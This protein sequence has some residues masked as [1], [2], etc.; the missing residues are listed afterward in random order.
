MTPIEIDAA[1]RI[2]EV[3]RSIRKLNQDIHASRIS[4][5]N[6]P[7][8]LDARGFERELSG[9]RRQALQSAITVPVKAKLDIPDNV[10]I[11]VKFDSASQN[12]TKNI[13]DAISAGFKQATSGN[14]FTGLFKGVTGIGTAL[15]GGIAS[16]L[17]SL[18]SGAVIGLT[19]PLGQKL[20]KGLAEGVE[21]ELRDVI[22]SF[23]L[24]G[25]SI[26]LGLTDE[27]L[28]SLGSDLKS[29]RSV[30]ESFIP[31]LQ[32]TTESAAGRN[33]AQERDRNRIKS[34]ERQFAAEQQR[35]KQQERLF[36]AKEQALN[37][38]N[39][40][41]TALSA[42]ITQK[43]ADF[44]TSAGLPALVASFQAGIN[45]LNERSALLQQKLAVPESLRS[46]RDERAIELLNKQIKD[47]SRDIKNAQTG[48]QAIDRS[49]SEQFGAELD[50]LSSLVAR[51]NKALNK[52]ETE[53]GRIDEVIASV[54]IRKD[55]NRGKLVD[56][57]LSSA[58]A[59]S[60]SA[61]QQSSSEIP[62]NIQPFNELV[63]LYENIEQA[64]TEL[65]NKNT[66][67]RRLADKKEEF[68]LEVDLIRQQEARIKLLDSLIK[69]QDVVETASP[70][71]FRELAKIIFELSNI[72]PGAGKTKLPELVLPGGN[73]LEQL[74]T[75]DT[76]AA[77]SEQLNSLVVDPNLFL[78]FTEQLELTNREVVEGVGLSIRELRK[79]ITSNLNGKNLKELSTADLP[80]TLLQ[81]TPEESELI[82]EQVA[83][84]FSSAGNAG[85]DPKVAAS[86]EQDALLFE[87]RYTEAIAK[88]IGLLTTDFNIDNFNE[89]ITAQ[90]TRD[91]NQSLQAIFQTLA[92]AS[93][94]SFD[95]I[96]DSIS[97]VVLPETERL[98]SL[99]ASHATARFDALS[100]QILLRPATF[101]ELAKG[102]INLNNLETE[103]IAHEIRHAF[104]TA[105]G[106]LTPEELNAGQFGV[107]LLK[108][109]KEEMKLIG[110]DIE[111]SVASALKNGS[112]YSEETIRAL[113]E[114]AY[115]FQL[116]AGKLVRSA[117]EQTV[118]KNSI[119]KNL[120]NLQ[121]SVS[122]PSDLEDS[123]KQQ[124][125]DA[126]NA[127]QIIFEE[128]IKA[129]DLGDELELL[130]A[131]IPDLKAI[132]LQRLAENPDLKGAYDRLFNQIQ[133]KDEDIKALEANIVD[134]DLVSF[135]AH[136]LRHSL[137]QMFGSISDAEFKGGE[138]GVELLK[139]TA[140][141]F[142]Q[143][144]DA[145]VTS[146]SN[147]DPDRQDIAQILE[148]DAYT[149]Q[150][151]FAESIYKA[152]RSRLESVNQQIQ[153]NESANPK[154]ES[155]KEAVENVE[156]NITNAQKIYEQIFR[157]VAE[158]SNFTLYDFDRPPELE[159]KSLPNGIKGQYKADSNKVSLS[160]KSFE[161]LNFNLI[162]KEVVDILVHEI[163]H[164]FQSELGKLDVADKLAGQFGVDLIEPTIEELAQISEQVNKSV[165]QTLLSLKNAGVSDKAIADIAPLLKQTET[166]AYTFSLRLHE[167]IF[168]SLLSSLR[169]EL[170]DIGDLTALSQEEI[171]NLFNSEQF[172]SSGL[173]ELVKRI[174]V[175]ASV[176]Q[177]ATKEELA[178]VLANQTERGRGDEIRTVANSLGDRLKNQKYQSFATPKLP[179]IDEQAYIKRL[180][181]ASANINEI[182][183]LLQSNPPQTL[184]QLNQH[185]KNLAKQIIARKDE[186]NQI[187]SI[188]DLSSETAQIIAGYKSRFQE[189]ALN[190]INAI[191]LS[192]NQTVEVGLSQLA[193]LERELVRA[194][195]DTQAR[196]EDAL[197]APK[198]QNG[199]LAVRPQVRTLGSGLPTP[200]S[201]VAHPRPLLATKPDKLLSRP[202]RE[203]IF[204][205]EQ[206]DAE[207][208]KENVTKSTLKEAIADYKNAII[209][210]RQELE[211]K[212]LDDTAVAADFE[213]G[214]ELAQTGQALATALKEQGGFSKE[215]RS[216]SRVSQTLLRKTD[217]ID[218][219]SS[220]VGE[221]VINGILEGI[222]SKLAV[223]FLQ[224]ETLGLELL[225]GF[226]QALDIKSPSGEFERAM[227]EVAAGG[228]KG[229]SNNSDRFSQIGQ[230]FAGD[231]TDNFT[232]QLILPAAPQVP[233]LPPAT[234]VAA[235]DFWDDDRSRDAEKY[236]EGLA[237]KN[238]TVL[239][240]F[241]KTK[242]QIDDLDAALTRL[243]ETTQT[244]AFP[245]PLLPP[246]TDVAAYDFWDDDRSRDAEKYVE[247]LADKNET[248]LDSFA[249]TKEQ[250]D[251]LD[252]AL[253]RL[254][255]TTQTAAFPTPL[256]PPAT[257]VAA[258]DFWDDDR[259]RDAEKYVEGLAA[260]DN[261]SLIDSIGRVDVAINSL[262]AALTR[263]DE[264]SV[265]D[266]DFIADP[267]V[268]GITKD[269]DANINDRRTLDQLI[270][271]IPVEDEIESI[272][273]GLEL[274]DPWIDL[275]DAIYDVDNSIA[276]LN[277]SVA[278]TPELTVDDDPWIDLNDAI[279]DV[280]NSIKRTTEISPEPS[281]IDEIP[282]AYVTPENITSSLTPDPWEDAQEQ[283]SQVGIKLEDLAGQ[284][285]EFPDP[286]SDI[287]PDPWEDAQ[288]QISQVGIKLED[289]AGQVEEFP[290]PWSDITPDPWEDAQEQISQV[291]I[292]LEDLAGQV[293]EFP[294]PWSDITPDPWED[295]QEQISQVGIKL[296]D[297]AGQVEEFP[298]P[299]S[300]IT[301]DPWE[302]A[303]EQISQVGIKLEDLAGQVEE[304][305]DPW[306]DSS[307]ELLGVHDING[308]LPLRPSGVAER[309]LEI[310]QDSI[311][312]PDLE[313][314]ETH[315]SGFFDRLKQRITDVRSAWNNLFTNNT[316]TDSQF[317]EAVATAEIVTA[318]IEANLAVVDQAVENSE[319][320]LEESN[321]AVSESV[322]NLGNETETISSKIKRLVKIGL[323]EFN[324]LEGATKRVTGA[325]KF[326]AAG[327]IA[328]KAV[329][330]LQDK[331]SQ[332][333]ETLEETIMRF[334][335][336]KK[337]LL[338]VNDRDVEKT[339]SQLKFLRSEA[340]RLKVSFL[341]AAEGFK[342]V[343][344]AARDTELEG[345]SKQ[346]YTSVSQAAR[347]L[348]LDGETVKGT[349]KALNDIIGK[350]VVQAEEI[351]GQ[352]GDRIPGAMQIAARAMGTTTQELSKL[353]ETGQVTSE[354]F[355]PKFIAQLEAETRSG[356]ADS[357]KS[358]SASIV[359]LENKIVDL[360]LAVGEALGFAENKTKAISV[361]VLALDAL[362][363]TIKVAAE[364]IPALVL[365]AKGLIGL[366]LIKFLQMA[367][368]QF[369]ALGNSLKTLALNFNAGAAS[370]MKLKRALV[371]LRRIARTLKTLFKG[372]IVVEALTVA[373]DTF[374]RLK[375]GIAEAKDGLDEIKQSYLDFQKAIVE[376]NPENE[377]LI[378][379]I[380][381][382]NIEAIKENR[383]W[384]MKLADASK[385][386]LSSEE[387][388]FL[389]AERQ[390][391]QASKRR[392]S[393][394]GLTYDEAQINQA[395]NRLTESIAEADANLSN[396]NIDIGVN[397]SEVET[398]NIREAIALVNRTI[399]GL[400]T[401][402]AT[403]VAEQEDL[404][405]AIA[406][407]KER[408]EALR[409]ELEKRFNL[410]KSLAKIILNRNRVSDAATEAEAEAIANID[411]E[412][413]LS[414]DLHRD[415]E[416]LKLQLSQQRIE[417][418][419]DN[420]LRTYEQFS[421]EITRRNQKQFNNEKVDLDKQKEQKL[422]TEKSYQ[423]AL[424]SL[425]EKY[426]DLDPDTGL[427]KNLTDEEI[428]QYQELRDGVR[429]IRTEMMENSLAIAQAEIDERLRIY[430]EH[431]EKLE[432]KRLAAENKA[433]EAEKERL[434]EIQQLVNDDLIDTPL[435]EQLKTN[436]TR[437]RISSELKQEK[438]KLR[439]LKRFKS[440][441]VEVQEKR[442]EDIKASRTKVLDLTLQLLEQ[443]KQAE[444]KTIE[445]I[446][447]LRDA[448]YS[449]LESN[450]NRLQS[451][452]QT[453]AQLI[454]DRASADE[455]LADLEL[456][457]LRQAVELRKQINSG[458]LNVSERRI[459]LRQLHSLGVKGRTNELSLLEKI[460]DREE[461]LAKDKLKNLEIQQAY[462]RQQLEIENQQLIIATNRAKIEADRNLI[463]AEKEVNSASS[464]IALAEDKVI[465]AKTDEELKAA[466]V[467][468]DNANKL[469]NLAQESLD[470]ANK[471]VDLSRHQLGLLDSTIAKKEENLRLTQA[472]ALAEAKG[473]S[474]DEKF[475]RERAEL[476]A[477]E[478]RDRRSFS[479]G[480]KI[481]LSKY[482]SDR[483]E[484]DRLVSDRKKKLGDKFSEEDEAKYRTQLQQGAIKLNARSDRNIY[485]ELRG[486]NGFTIE[487][488]P[489]VLDAIRSGKGFKVPVVP[490][491]K[492]PLELD[493]LGK[494]SGS[495]SQDNMILKTLQNIEQKFKQP[496][497]VNNDNQFINQYQRNDLDEI[498]RQTRS[499][500]VDIV[501]LAAK[502]L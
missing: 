295:A 114:D 102:G 420:E 193:E 354:E 73:L 422:I 183:S 297:L 443:E 204:S 11:A 63:E 365:A 485:R 171:I 368:F 355:I 447:L 453:E 53:V 468:L 454:S 87:L 147:A 481:D 175:S 160:P 177:S 439:Q 240:S 407:Q 430:D 402:T 367:A 90:I 129:S 322:N 187:T 198:A 294:D 287:T 366:G 397:L 112:A 488:P 56:F 81:P 497:V 266:T 293:E 173:K 336:L 493:V 403:T 349:F 120:N 411:K 247:G 34:A 254:D 436:L 96:A 357:T 442:D 292:K 500:L 36:R 310:R 46:D 448:A 380:V 54:Q 197:L 470:L 158:A 139:A 273:N 269:I 28:T 136:E 55:A 178:T 88:R 47:A 83:R 498:L 60:F 362:S 376:N 230:D 42:K 179:T 265:I 228:E 174:G 146:V 154:N 461:K 341:D 466:N 222:E 332:F 69:S 165:A 195:S 92:A 308:H 423:D 344:G 33:D 246:A 476:E 217:A 153:V 416:L 75:T 206:I 7:T 124:V 374:N 57:E 261:N 219:A 182:I 157:L 334:D 164:A 85:I 457:K 128:V 441:E 167:K 22:G 479:A 169:P 125:T 107:E 134:F 95:A 400:K 192:K 345:L 236:V 126:Q 478:R 1:L 289:L 38:T 316:D 214:R 61:T 424:S 48:I 232:P 170:I 455:K 473:T 189:L 375:N 113:E 285:E 23:D 25:R 373:I 94:L 130:I 223:V 414:G 79:Q 64:E 484:I 224:G 477:R 359:D 238:E 106:K 226:K 168:N 166:D 52:F 30:F 351:R 259:S 37:D 196:S 311:P 221:E 43:I 163:R 13:T 68:Q 377:L 313:T 306:E 391:R 9:L 110:A 379:D 233:L 386:F 86:I 329:E 394:F 200:L 459:A 409:K 418:Q 65:K 291:G 282:N 249:K 241:A 320:Q 141:E 451:L 181:D 218:I 444:E 280:V 456:A 278:A 144:G 256:L 338:F 486:N 31:S 138:S 281:Q 401:Q 382:Q 40:K 298:D 15:F 155:I 97:S 384:Y 372:F 62:Q 286:W 419:Y 268:E 239:D 242:E 205:K 399:A 132:S 225:K 301:P 135:L 32:I 203:Q 492:Q 39:D 381:K 371:Q 438:E 378:E 188:N 361:A 216:L 408:A 471:D 103:T 115:V 325:F 319:R 244:A 71:R 324:N 262:D 502:E 318:N 405:A 235:Y 253:T 24:V 186:I 145:L 49:V 78:A 440:S 190:I 258:Y 305:L 137:E 207:V 29:M 84:L 67:N 434:I 229:A 356:L 16:T 180:Q 390:K 208:N 290:D 340:D 445:A 211:Q 465:N 2:R 274:D 427:P 250:I 342:A 201:S 388:G 487:A 17:G 302:D 467:E 5:L 363:L 93:G 66:K 58:P 185:L 321:D 260:S 499:D 10:A 425:K 19:L 202:A 111:K 299:W 303:Q 317:D 410:E 6:I 304:F 272:Y 248:V 26:G 109:T 14:I 331:F 3:D 392:N 117:I 496:T 347:V 350:G 431:F 237:D 148:E 494:T 358:L 105:F 450:L 127:Y 4:P 209:K 243:D 389:S 251:D 156:N 184:L 172:S 352:L 220:P 480:E 122:A 474:S 472:I 398:D 387:S 404:N 51:Y 490:Q 462:A 475:D 346:I 277:N 353:I 215:A 99:I 44:E 370:S 234:D 213:A 142:S 463:N 426:Q 116:R 437:D 489:E 212:I 161:D 284:V 267:D 343:A 501:N 339:E 150:L 191:A 80:D 252:A 270:D 271:S 288:E 149:F 91:A 152:V 385:K 275:K 432:D 199:R 123:I 255:E 429:A 35:L 20:G 364:S 333:T 12:L 257:D 449:V 435:A 227:D 458:E 8:L 231:I 133:L 328:V 482:E 460:A 464:A 326:L 495:L 327:I 383:N 245:T 41:I 300:D 421:A 194:T 263:L 309:G 45:K 330:F 279:D 50:S 491:S 446:A 72:D 74:L 98:R 337:G 119:P 469:Y 143:F 176:Y 483:L 104:Q 335:D 452:Y 21:S 428:K 108:A 276:D 369:F 360:Q 395:S 413:L 101:N 27:I 76:L 18:I 396:L 59:S 312:S 264:L 70:D 323:K 89:G 151:R 121:S 162:T 131:S 417:T 314:T 283:I 210:Y 118:N 348:Q 159:P 406:T 296:E 307:P 82:G 412:T 140:E 393:L 415:V 77:F 433:I 100:N 315:S